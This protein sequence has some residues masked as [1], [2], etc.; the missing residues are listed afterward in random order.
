MIKIL[1]TKQQLK[2]MKNRHGTL[3]GF[4]LLLKPGQRPLDK[5]LLHFCTPSLLPMRCTELE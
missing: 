2:T 4:P 3:F 1:I 5:L